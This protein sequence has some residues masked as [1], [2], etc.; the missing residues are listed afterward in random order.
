MEEDG[1]LANCVRTQSRHSGTRVIEHIVECRK[2]DLNLWTVGMLIEKLRE[3]NISFLIAISVTINWKCSSS[4]IVAY[5]VCVCVCVQNKH[6][7][8]LESPK[9]NSESGL[10]KG[11]LRP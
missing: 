11:Q 3:L 4:Q 9:L 6:S 2:P 5:I 10:C 8:I 1:I 7:H